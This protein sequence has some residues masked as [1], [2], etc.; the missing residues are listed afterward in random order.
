MATPGA[1]EQNLPLHPSRSKWDDVEEE[2]PIHIVPKK[3]P[4]KSARVRQPSPD[5]PALSREPEEEP[6]PQ[7][8]PRALRPAGNSPPR[9]TI[10]TRSRFVPPRTAHPAIQPC[11]SV[12]CYERLN[13]IEEGTYGV[14]FR[15]RDKE[16]G[17]IVALKKLKLDEEKN[18]FPITSL[19]EVMALMVCKHEH[20]VGVREIVVGETLTQVFIVMDFIEHDLKQLLTQMPKPFLQSEIKTLLRQLISAVAHCHTN[21]V[22]HR[23]LKTSNLLMNNRGQI[24]V[25]DFGLARTFGDP[26]GDMTQLVVTLW[27]R[28]PELLLGETAYSTAVD[29]WSVGCIF[30]ELLLHE[31]LFQA[32]G[33]MELLSMIFKL[34]GHPD[35]S[36]WPGFSKLPLAKTVNIS[37]AT[38]S[39]LPIRFPQLTRAGLDLLSSLLA[40]DPAQRIS[41]EDALNHPYF[42]ESPLPKHPSLFGSFPS[43]AAGEKKRKP[44]SP[45]APGRVAD[46]KLLMD[47]DLP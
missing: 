26:L 12:Y 25:A 42:S 18:G 23:D 30:G 3:R 43:L 31:P 1:G 47:F 40:Y 44:D 6:I 4:K 27:Y 14:V 46:Y 32:K 38:P 45:S 33:E 13:H 9:P 21:W 36:S 35:E 24:K 19:R 28:A 15:A 2:P 11:R 10:S 37:A 8:T 7:I 17:E 34:L 39:T 5:V 29:M 22:L 20:V 41:A 16:T